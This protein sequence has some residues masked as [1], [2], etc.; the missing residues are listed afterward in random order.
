MFKNGLLPDP[1][2]EGFLRGRAI[3]TPLSK[4]LDNFG[5]FVGD[6]YM[7]WLGKSFSAKSQEGVN[8]F[9]TSARPLLKALWPTYVPE[10]E[11]SD[12]IEAFP[13]KTRVSRGAVDPDVEVLK[14]DYDF[15]ANPPAVRRVLD[16]L[17]QVDDG[18]Y[19]GKVLYRWQS[20]FHP[21]GFFCLE[22]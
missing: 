16:E 7:P 2:P 22:R 10:R 11:L 18:L 20:A 17:V 9:T 4:L 12:R 14:I 15:E 6:F 13:L 8:V 21:I 1:L 19:L 5:R 3:M